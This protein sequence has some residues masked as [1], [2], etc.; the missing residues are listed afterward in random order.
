MLLNPQGLRSYSVTLADALMPAVEYRMPGGLLWDELS[1]VL[2]VAFASGRARGLDV[3]IF[4]P[5]LDN[6]GS[7]ARAFVGALGRGLAPGSA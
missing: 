6:D 3:T 7:I 1:A 2:R 4:N 5:R